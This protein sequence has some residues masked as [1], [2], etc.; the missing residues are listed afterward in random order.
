MVSQQKFMLGLSLLLSVSLFPA[1]GQV[2]STIE[3][4]TIYLSG[5]QIERKADVSLVKGENEVV[6]VGLP[7]SL[8]LGSIQVA[9]PGVK[10]VSIMPSYSS[11]LHPDSVKKIDI[12]SD[13]LELFEQKIKKNKRETEGFLAEE[14]ILTSN[15]QRL[16]SEKGISL[17]EL[18]NFSAYYQKRVT[19]LKNKIFEFEEQRMSWEKKSKTIANKIN[20][21]KSSSRPAY[22][23][24]IKLK[25]D[26][27]TNIPLRLTYVAL[28]AGWSP[29]YDVRVKSVSEKVK[30]N[31]RASLINDTQEDWI[32]VK[33]KLSSS[34]PTLSTQAPEL[35]VWRID[36]VRQYVYADKRKLEMAQ[37]AQAAQLNMRNTLSEYEEFG[38]ES[39]DD[40]AGFTMSRAPEVPEADVNISAL[41]I[42]FEIKEPYSVP[43]DGKNYSVDVNEY[44]LVAQYSY[45]CV[46]KLDRDAFLIA[47]IVGWEQLNL[48]EGKMNLY[49]AETYVGESYLNPR[50]ASDTLKIS[51][52]R[53]KK[54]IVKRVEIKDFSKTAFIGS[55]KRESLSTEIEVRNTNNVPIEIEILDQIPISKNSDIEVTVDNLD[56]ASRD[57]EKGQLRWVL[58]LKE[59]ESKRLRFEYTVKYPKSKSIERSNYQSPQN[60]RKMY[61][62]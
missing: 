4:V 54:V 32:N 58:K 29:F 60:Q 9:S 13:S 10:L 1:F 24:T 40:D 5:A 8:D 16:G 46:P 44:D 51:L 28:S 12:L 23:L 35:D 56:G 18:Q 36:F 39:A 19:E 37:K 22:D 17:L 38:A 41:S 26:A 30:L 2:K 6:F 55:N 53:D 31:Y 52:G 49:F 27:P 14:K 21:L 48:I 61:K 43:S 57:I 11:Y 3:S 47:G 25:A 7:A 15:M 42:E 50:S 20:S 34:N 59:T 62:R 33:L 45:K